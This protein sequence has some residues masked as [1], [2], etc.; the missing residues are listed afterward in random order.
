MIVRIV[1]GF[2]L[3]GPL[4]SASWIR[5]GTTDSQFRLVILIAA[6]LEVMNGSRQR[7]RDAL[8]RLQ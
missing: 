1:Y 8:V 3:Y 7:W 4:Q 2:L 5:W 6:S